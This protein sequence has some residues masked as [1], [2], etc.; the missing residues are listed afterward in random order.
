MD[1]GEPRSRV[2]QEQERAELRGRA[3]AE[4]VRRPR[5][6]C[7][8][9]LPEAAHRGVVPGAEEGIEARTRRRVHAT[10]TGVPVADPAEVGRLDPWQ[11]SLEAHPAVVQTTVERGTR[12]PYRRRVPGSIR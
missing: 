6:V 5:D 11:I 2:V 10:D 8:A 1:R 4:C 3:P 9:E 12:E 7:A